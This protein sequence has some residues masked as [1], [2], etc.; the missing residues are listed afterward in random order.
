MRTCSS[1]PAGSLLIEIEGG[2]KMTID[3]LRKD[4]VAAIKRIRELLI[5][6]KNYALIVIFDWETEYIASKY[7][8]CSLLT[9]LNEYEQ[10][11]PVK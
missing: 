7:D 10:I 6:S 9:L 5:T 4:R 1:K 3:E 8:D 2:E 11:S